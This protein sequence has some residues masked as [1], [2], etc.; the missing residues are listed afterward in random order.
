MSPQNC[1]AAYQ[2]SKT[3][4]C[5]PSE[6]YGI[7]GQPEAFYFDRAVGTF[8]VHLEA[9]LAEVENHGKK[10]KAQKAMA[11]SMILRR[12]LGSGEF[13]QP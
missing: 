10:S 7:E 4:R 8:G 6:L 2:L 11:R 12:Y 9:K 13:A 5:R 3:Y 1:W